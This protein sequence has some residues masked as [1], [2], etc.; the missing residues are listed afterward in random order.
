MIDIEDV[1][2]RADG[3]GFVDL[4]NRKMELVFKLYP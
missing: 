2:W 4:D 3:G 1:G